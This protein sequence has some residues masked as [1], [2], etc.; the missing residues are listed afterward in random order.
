[1]SVDGT[2]DPANHAAASVDPEIQAEQ[3]HLDRSHRGLRM[4]R[5]RSEQLLAELREAGKPDLDYEAA[6]LRRIA[7]LGE[8]RRPL[9][10]G[11]IDEIAGPSWRVG[12]RHVEDLKGDVLV[13]DWRAPISTSFYRAR[14]GD[15]LGL[16]RRRQIMVDGT[17]VIAVADDLFGPGHE[18]ADRTRLRGGD[19]LLAEL[20]RARTGEML[21]IVATIQ[22][23]QDEIIRSPLEGLLV[24]Q[25]GPGTG[26]TAVA[27]H[28]AAYLLYNHPELARSGVLVIGPSRAF[29]RYIAQVLPSLGEEA[30]LQMTIGDLV[31]R[32]RVRGDDAPL[33]GRT[34]GDVRMAKVIAR[35]LELSRSPI[36]E[37]V[38][39]KARYTVI[40]LESEG[41][42]DLVATIAAR[43]M[44]YS[45][46]RHAL[47]AR[48]VSHARH[49]LRQTGRYEGD[50][51][52]FEREL[53]AGPEFSQLRDRLWPRV[54]P[55]QLVTDL[56]SRPA[57][58]ERA[59]QGLLDAKEIAALHRRRPK[60]MGRTPWT[61]DDIALIDEANFLINGQTH[62]YGH[63]VVDEAQDLSP[64]QLRMLARRAPRGS[65]TVLGDI[66]Q[67]TGRWSYQSWDEIAPHLPGAADSRREEL[68]LGYR[69][70]GQVLDLA[71]RLLPVSAPT[72]QPTRSVRQGRR[73]PRIIAVT[74]DDLVSESLAEARRLAAE[75]FLVGLIVPPGPVDAEAAKA[76]AG[77]DDVARLDEL[78]IT[79]SITLLPAPAAKGLEFD[80]VVV[81]EPTLIAGDEVRGLRLLYVALTRPIQHLTIVH[82]RPLPALLSEPAAS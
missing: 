17:K 40:T 62:T 12:R 70:P 66:A 18:D 8:S 29:L 50:E 21:D 3:L 36:T 59:G 34:K 58:L 25:G 57:L 10:F 78:G 1:M 51:P 23:E 82:A 5:E 19:A 26:K 73:E 42:N 46:G 13:V 27:L 2:Q 20:E 76:I 41:V 37:P 6:F 80:A 39:V 75:G 30:V 45:A 71:S 65:L 43:G 49:R 31:S 74:R 44:P 14:P 11:R 47:Q 9:L 64:M 55:A 32:T 15:P 28:R 67:A 7:L 38:A 16:K 79:R 56:L 60:S 72:V 48:L 69:A 81:V 53:R 61:L 24:V 63:V 77:A 22:G 4:M 54:S 35:A 52:W 33:A 68:T